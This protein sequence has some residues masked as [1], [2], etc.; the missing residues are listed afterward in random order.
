MRDF[1][2]YDIWK[3]GIETSTKIY[4]LTKSFPADEKFGITSQVRRASVSI[5]SNFAEG[6]SSEKDFKRFIE[7]ALGSAFELKTQLIIAGRLKYINEGD[8]NLLIESIDKSSK[9]L[10]SL[11]NKLK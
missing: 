3:D 8:L 10:N 7:I 2:K 1:L 5:V 4:S 11:R 9:Q 6:C